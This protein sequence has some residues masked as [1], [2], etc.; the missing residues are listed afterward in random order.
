LC[1]GEEKKYYVFWVYVCS[2]SYSACKGHSP[3]FI[4]TCYLS[5][6]TILFTSSHKRQD[7]RKSVSEHKMC[8]VIFSKLLSE[9]FLI[10]NRI[11]RVFFL[12]KYLSFCK[13]SVFLVKFEWNINIPYRFLKKSSNIRFHIHPSNESWVLSYGQTCLD[14]YP[15]NSQISN[16]IKIR[17]MEHE[18]FHSDRHEAKSALK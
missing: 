14:S 12:N 2:L 10:L 3:Y 5:G 13:V 18:S 1:R 9:Y 4:V 11:E 15:K 8:V 7:F 6:C 16:F 17:P